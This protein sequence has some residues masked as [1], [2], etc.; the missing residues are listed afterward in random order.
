MLIR[1]AASLTAQLYRSVCAT[2]LARE[3]GT[4]VLDADDV[5]RHLATTGRFQREWQLCGCCHEDDVV[6]MHVPSWPLVAHA[7]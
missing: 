4:T 6:L 1:T 2:C 3:L 7:V 5:A